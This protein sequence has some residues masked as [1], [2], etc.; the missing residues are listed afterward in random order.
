[1]AIRVPT[2]RERQV[3]QQAVPNVRQ[4]IDTPAAA[5][6]SL[7]ADAMA[8]AGTAITRLGEQ[9]NR[10][11]INLQKETNELYALQLQTD[12]EREMSDFLY[13][14]QAGLLTQK[15]RN[16]LD[17]PKMTAA[18]L[19]EIQKRFGNQK[20]IPQDVRTMLQKGM[21]QMGRR[22]GD[23][24]N[25]H[26]LGEYTT[27]KEQ[28]LQAR[29][30]LNMQDIAMNYMDDSEFNKKA[31]ENFKLLQ[32]RATSE[33]WDDSKLQSEKLRLYSAQRA[34]QITSMIA[35]DEPQNILVA[36]KVYQEAR[37]RNQ[38]G[39]DDSLKI[40]ALLDKAV[41][42]AAAYIAYR[43]GRLGASVT[44]E[45]GIMAFVIDN[46][47]GG[48]QIAQEPD[49]AI[50]KYGIN[51]KWNP[52]VDVENL[53]RA[54]AE[55]LYKERYWKPYGIDEVPE[56]MR[57]LAFDIA[58]NHRSDFAKKMIG[59]IKNG[60]M[61]DKIMNARLKEYQRLAQSEPDKYGKYYAGWKDRLNRISTQMS[62]RMPVDGA[63]VYSA[64]RQLESQ[65]KGS[66]AELIALYDNDQKA[67]AAQQTAE[68]NETQDLVMQMN[69]QNNGDWTKIPAIVRERA[70]R[71]GIDVTQYKGQSDPEIVSELDAMTSSELFSTDLNDAR[72]AQNLT[73][74]QHQAYKKK[75]QELQSP[76]NKYAADMIDGVVSYYFRTQNKGSAGD[77]NSTFNKPAIAQMKNY[78]TFKANEYRKANG[79]KN[80]SK[81]D[82]TK[83]ASEYLGQIKTF[84]I[85]S[86]ADIAESERKVIEAELLRI[87]I[88]PTNEAVMAVYMNTRGQKK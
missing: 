38:I 68:K 84:G 22:Y 4:Q 72:Y 71:H 67:K 28:T 62:D 33:G 17:A 82:I 6:G 23:L 57:L 35:S 30:E 27:Y 74:D 36:Q 48:D 59:E 18:K 61:P 87:G 47:E 26:A 7:Q 12:A 13:D 37:N 49:G 14:P 45:S 78:V 43:T 56:N 32:S 55:N 64:A 86:A 53:S 80:P 2:Y 31:D 85:K 73:Y 5:F 19:D 10:K 44:D 11:A 3:Q 81:A 1:M 58:V 76:E 88:A 8:N 60:A 70:A 42:K 41:P 9:W 77:T 34:T 66:G 69:T 65:Y 83:F 46:L 15:G 63:A 39:F 54:G 75:Q 20:D 29:M 79:N 21:I 50:A 16:A 52:D 51:S 40:E 24:A 25:R